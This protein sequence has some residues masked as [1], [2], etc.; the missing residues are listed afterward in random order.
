MI[1]GRSN[2]IIC[3][4][5]KCN[6]TKPKIRDT[7]LDCLLGGIYSGIES[8]TKPLFKNS[9]DCFFRFLYRDPTMVPTKSGQLSNLLLLSE[10]SGK[11]QW[12]QRSL[13]GTQKLM[14]KVNSVAHLS[15]VGM[16][17]LILNYIFLFGLICIK[18]MLILF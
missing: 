10:V 16:D 11:A 14:R 13:T 1:I 12:T 3:L 9:L 15:V 7:V 2:T 18:M 5:S 4:R 8:G 6:K 17:S